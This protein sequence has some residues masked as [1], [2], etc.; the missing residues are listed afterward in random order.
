[1]ARKLNADTAGEFPV[2]QLRRVAGLRPTGFVRPH[3]HRACAV[4]SGTPIV[5]CASM[6]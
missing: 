2:E 3:M 4:F 6:G 1:M 5:L